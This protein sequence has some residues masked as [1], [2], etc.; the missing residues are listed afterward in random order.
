MTD[1]EQTSPATVLIVE[2][3]YLIASTMSAALELAD[4]RVL[5]PFPSV[6]TAQRALDEGQAAAIAV[7]DVNL[8]G[9]HAFPL[10]DRLVES[11]VPIVLTTGYDEDAIPPAYANIRRLQKP[12]RMHAL[13]ACLKSMLRH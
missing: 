7:L 5:G 13:I 3:D 6:A 12:V 10:I 9:E 4:W 11:G 8:G 2:D 1:D